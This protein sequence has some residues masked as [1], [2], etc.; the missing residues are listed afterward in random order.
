MAGARHRLSGWRWEQLMS[1]AMPQ[2]SVL[3]VDDN[4]VNLQVLSALLKQMD[5]KVFVAINGETTL[6]R[7]QRIAPDLILL[8]VMM[9]DLDGF[10][11]CRRLKAAPQTAAIPVIFVAAL[12]TVEH[13]VKGFEVGGA[14][15]ITKPF[16]QAE[17]AARVQHQLRLRQLTHDLEQEI[18]A[19]R[20]REAALQRSET[21]FRTL[22]DALPFGVWMRDAEDRLVMQNPVDV[23]RYGDQL[24]TVGLDDLAFTPEQAT[25]YEEAKQH[26]QMGQVWQYQ[27]TEIFQGEPHTYL[28]LLAPVPDLEGGMAWLEPLSTLRSTIR[29]SLNCGKAKR[30]FAPF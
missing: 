21:R 28:R 12:A 10:E 24:G 6:Q 4:P 23:A 30:D 18:A 7:A 25:V 15:Y 1:S 11:V 29:P 17:V 26:C 19:R 13:K 27:T 16:Q 8:D 22:I 3:I 9:P 2:Q 20:Q 5:L 14:D